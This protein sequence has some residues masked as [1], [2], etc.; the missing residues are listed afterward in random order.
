M[1]IDPKSLSKAV[2]IS[3]A[4]FSHFRKA[5]L[6]MM[7][8]MV[9]RFYKSGKVHAAGSIDEGKSA[10]IN[11]LYQAA[12]TLVPNLVYNDPRVKINT[13][14]I[15]YR[16]YAELLGLAVDHTVQKIKLRDTLRKI[17]MDAIFLA[18]FAKTGLAA[19]DEVLK[20]D[21][22]DL[23]L[24]RPYI[25]RVDPDDMI[26]D[27]MARDWD[28][29]SFIGNRY[30]A[31]LDQLMEMGIYDPAKPWRRCPAATTRRRRTSKPCRARKAS[32]SRRSAGTSIWWTCTCP[33]K[34]WSARCPTR[35]ATWRRTSYTPRST[36]ARRT[37]RTTCW[38]S[39]PIPDNILPVAPA[40]IW[41]DL[42]ILGNRIARKLARQAERS[43]RVL[44]Y[45]GEAAEDAMR[46]ADAED[47]EGVR[48]EDVDKVKEVNYGG[49]S[50]D[51][52]EW[53]KWVKGTFSE[54]AGSIELLQGV[55]SNSPTA[56]QA[57]M[58]QSNAS[59]RLGDM[60]NT[61][62]NFTAEVMDDVKFML[63]T[64]PMIELPIARRQFGQEQQAYF[65]PDVR[66]GEWADFNLTTKPY[67]MAR[68]D[69]DKMQR[70]RLDFA[71]LV[72]PA[73]AQ[74]MQL[75][76]PGFKVGVFLRNMARDLQMEDVDEWIDDAAFQQWMMVQAQA[77]M[78]SGL[79][80]G[81]AGGGEA[82]AAP[83]PGMVPGQ[84]IN[85]QPNPT[86]MG[87]QG[88]VSVDTEQARAQQEAA[89]ELQA[90][91]SYQPSIRALAMQRG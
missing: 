24:G 71:T 22:A 65:T 72:I 42:H 75:L 82:P 35:R 27:P 36:P 38:P 67:S 52:Y 29:Q 16:D 2:D 63:H 69:P 88:G 80:P 83:M 40:G 79:D 37:A 68:S 28:E 44:A 77:Q 8:Q 85:G 50:E 3:F 32:G 86:A 25:E 43:K 76:G 33:G 18:G 31:D 90:G 4:K 17:I 5:R 7:S 73:A 41:Y 55:N 48:V 66:Q 46:I 51:S 1:K 57:E 15:A 70:R 54:Q 14:L 49:A 21:G 59:V 81:K 64:D 74:A 53:M 23:P 19:G 45:Q 26:L 60:Q 47:G 91:S 20:Y 78:Q 6:L 39:R 87:P 9:G 62:Y 34:G 61:V 56:T 11:L 30:R 58:L 89:G 84:P 13:P 10:P 12:S